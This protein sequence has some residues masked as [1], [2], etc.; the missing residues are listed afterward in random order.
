MDTLTIVIMLILFIIAMIFVF[1][2]AL[3]T[4]YIGKKN[5]VSVILLGLI[6]GVVGGAFLLSP[7]VDDIPDFSRTIIEENVEGTDQIDMGLS[8]NGNLTQ[9]IEN[10]SSISG[11]QNVAYTGITIKIDEPF[12]TDTDKNSF[13]TKLNSSSDAIN[14][15][16]DSGNN[17]YFIEI[18]ENGDPQSVLNSIYSVFGS[19]TSV[20]LRYTSMDA[21]ATVVANNITKIMNTISENGAVIHNVTGPTE[22]Q[23]NLVNQYI[24]DETGVVIL[25][26]VLGVIVAILGFF[27]DSIFSIIKRNKKSKKESSKDRIKRKA[28][29]PSQR[30][31]NPS[32]KQGNKNNSIDI[33]D[34]TFDKSPKQNI[35]SNKNFKQLTEEDLKQ[36]EETATK[37]VPEKV[38]KETKK[39]G[40]F[41]KIFKKSKSKKSKNKNS[42]KDSNKRKTPKIKPRRK[43]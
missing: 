35:G 11:V 12:D 22:D 39:Q 40:F 4:P 28:V 38:E 25:S 18:S 2:T 10:I 42:K 32:K 26:A 27:I 36:K 8:T 17:T 20:H 14:G 6:V 3:L 31:Y 24:P 9:I 16:E 7:I 5:L 41:S 15:V 13:F 43:E 23:V 30:K 19:E 1:S 21:N 33:F 37:D 29:P 34:E